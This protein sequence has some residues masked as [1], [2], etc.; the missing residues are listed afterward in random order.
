MEN[1]V[2]HITFTKVGNDLLN[3]TCC[4]PNLVAGLRMNWAIGGTEIYQHIGNNFI[5]LNIS[6]IISNIQNR[7]T[8]PTLGL[9]YLLTA[10]LTE[11]AEAEWLT[12]VVVGVEGL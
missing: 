3:L 1:E 12:I 6:L 4:L 2:L 11:A 10:V 8:Y 5:L 7:L 9:N